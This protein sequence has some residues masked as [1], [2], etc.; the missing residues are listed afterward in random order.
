MNC[1]GVRQHPEK[2]IPKVIQKV[3]KGEVV[4]IHSSPDK[5]VSGSR[6]YIS[7]DCISDAC[8]FIEHLGP[9]LQT[10]N[11]DGVSLPIYNLVGAEETSNLDLANMIA[12]SIGLPLKYEMVDFH[13]Q[14]PGHDL[15]YGLDGSLLR[16]LGW[17][18]KASVSSKIKEITDWYLKN[19]KWLLG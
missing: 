14:R 9:N 15:R 16:E 1:F 11:T 8:M 19:P 13:S 17:Q 6:F 4:E 3:L 18:P 7:Q 12:D 10:Q 2:F 5:K